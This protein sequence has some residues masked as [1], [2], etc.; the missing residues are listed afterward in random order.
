METVTL[1]LLVPAVPLHDPS[2]AELD[3]LEC[4]LLRE[5]ADDDAAPVHS[6]RA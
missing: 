6:W 5:T 3:E 1:S 4:A 2:D